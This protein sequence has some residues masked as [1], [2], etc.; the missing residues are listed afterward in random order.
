MQATSANALQ[1]ETFDLETFLRGCMPRRPYC[2][3]EL[4][5][6]HIRSLEQALRHR[7]VQHNPPGIVCALVFDVDRPAAAH[8]WEDGDLPSP[9][10]AVTTQQNG[11]AHLG[12]ALE[13]PVFIGDALHQRPARYAA[14]IEAAYAER[15]RSDD[16]YAGLIMKNPLHPEWLLAPWPGRRFHLGEL[17]EYVDLTGPRRSRVESRGIGRNVDLFDRLR[18]W[19]YEAVLRFRISGGIE[20]WRAAVLAHAD[21]LN[22]FTQP[23]P[24]VEVSHIARSVGKWVWNRY[25]SRLD[26]HLFS[27]RQA[28]RGALKG[29][30][31]RVQGIA[32]LHSGHHFVHVARECGVSIRTVHNWRATL[33][34]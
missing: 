18:H 21:A 30:Q 15:L 1:L 17:A 28:A 27:A 33:Q 31:A 12:Y 29:R 8:A 6:L 14:A 22:T 9:T 34:K 24:A 13:H 5:S 32:M 3:D 23:L 19:S 20:P 11:H 16:G 2:T 26:D 10:W 4:G 7:Y 25:T